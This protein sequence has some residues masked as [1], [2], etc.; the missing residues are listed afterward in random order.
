[1]QLACRIC[2]I[3]R[4]SFSSGGLG[5]QLPPSRPRQ[6]T[7]WQ[8]LTQAGE[9]ATMLDIQPWESPPAP[10]KL[11]V[12]LIGPTNAGKSTLL[13]ALLDSNVS[14]VS[15][16]I[17]TTR[18]NTI[19]FLTDVEQRTQLA[20]IAMAQVEFIDAPGA[21]GPEVPVLGRQMWD[22]VSSADL[23]LV[24]VDA[25]APGSFEQSKPGP[26]AVVSSFLSQLGREL[27]NSFS[28]T[29]QRTETALILN[30]VDRVYPKERLLKLSA[31]L[32]KLHSFDAPCFMIS[33]LL[34]SGTKHLRN[35]MILNA[36]PGEWTAPPDR[37]HLQPP[38]ELATEIIRSQIFNFFSKGGLTRCLSP[39]V[40]VH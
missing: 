18:E 1:M 33:A 19:G 22:A 40:T 32:H 6:T 11:R 21:C 39:T 7:H 24:M 31:R 9:K 26:L 4:L 37:K 30:K 29:G 38:L 3:R 14:A 8:P 2:S 34:R 17:H 25:S 16:K 23:A 35:Y 20:S 27:D 10:R 5:S 12:C 13:N 15:N 36:R 28:T